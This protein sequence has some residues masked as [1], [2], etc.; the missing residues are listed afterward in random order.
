MAGLLQ[1]GS[2]RRAAERLARRIPNIGAIQ[3]AAASALQGWTAHIHERLSA[4]VRARTQAEP[5][6]DAGSVEGPSQ[7]KGLSQSHGRGV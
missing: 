3:S 1:D 2:I 5:L 7:S 6:A 4:S